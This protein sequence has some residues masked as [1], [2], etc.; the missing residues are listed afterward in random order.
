MKK[1]M[2]HESVDESVISFNDLR[3]DPHD[4]CILFI[5]FSYIDSNHKNEATCIYI[6][7]L[8]RT[9]TRPS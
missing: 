2:V 8:Q 3:K 7:S 4:P 9:W 6:W 5:L 1:I